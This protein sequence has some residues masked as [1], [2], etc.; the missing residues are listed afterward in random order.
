MVM[1]QNK[2]AVTALLNCLV[3]QPATFKVPA[4]MSTH[5]APEVAEGGAVTRL[6]DIYSYGRLVEDVEAVMRTG[7]PCLYQIS[8]AYIGPARTNKRPDLEAIIRIF[9]DQEDAMVD[10]RLEDNVLKKILRLLPGDREP[11]VTTFVMDFE[12]GMW[13][14]VKGVAGLFPGKTRRG[15]AFHWTQAVYRKIQELG[16]QEAYRRREGAHRLLRN[17]SLLMLPHEHV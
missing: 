2:Q 14:A 17:L 15:C 7:Y 12:Q 16:L 3:E 1:T 10:V 8:T 13:Q 6:S 11:K 4:G 9:E 5:I